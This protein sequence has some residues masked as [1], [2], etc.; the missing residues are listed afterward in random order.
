[1]CDKFYKPQTKHIISVKTPILSNLYMYRN[2]KKERERER[3]RQVCFLTYM[4]LCIM[5]F[6]HK[7]CTPTLPPN[8]AGKK[9]WGKTHLKVEYGW[10]VSPQWQCTLC[11]TCVCM[12]VFVCVSHYENKVT[13]TP[14]LSSN[15]S[16][17]ATCDLMTSCPKTQD[18]IKG[19]EDLVSPWFKQNCRHICWVSNNEYHTITQCFKPSQ[20]C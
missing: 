14:F 1:M 6:F 20:D 12:H 4:Q 3:A 8:T 18:G 7:N 2:K 13:I 17:L 16:D 19:I 5:N 10:I 15:L 11:F 9:M